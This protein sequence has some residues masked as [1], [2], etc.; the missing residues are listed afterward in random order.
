MSTTVATPTIPVRYYQKEADEAI[1]QELATSD[2][3]LV[4]MFCGTGKSLVMRY[5]EVA[6][7]K[8]LVVYV[9]PSLTLIHQFYTNYLQ[10]FPEQ[11]I[12]KVS[13]DAG[14]TTD[15]VAIEH[16]LSLTHNKI[17]CVTYNSYSMFLRCLDEQFIDVCIYDEAHH[18]MALTYSRQIFDDPELRCKKQVFFTATIKPKSSTARRAM[19][20][21]DPNVINICGNLV[22][23]YTFNQGVSEGYLSDFDV[24]ADIYKNKEQLSVYESISRAVLTT[25]NSRVLTFHCDVQADRRMSVKNFVDEPA[26]TKIFRTIQA[27]E[28]P[29]N[30][31][32]Y[33]K[34]V[35]YGIDASIPN[36]ERVRILN[37]MDQS[38]SSNLII[39]SS[40]NTVG[41]GVDTKR[42]N[43]CVFTEAKSSQLQ[44]IQNIGRIVRKEPGVNKPSTILIPCWID[45]Q[46]YDEFTPGTMDSDY[47]LRRDLFKDG[48]NFASILNVLTALKQ[49]EPEKFAMCINY[50]KLITKVNHNRPIADRKYTILP[51]YKDGSIGKT[52]N[53]MFQD[54]ISNK[55]EPVNNDDGDDDIFNIP[56]SMIVDSDIINYVSD[57]T[58]S[59]IEI[60]DKEPIRG[61]PVE[62]YS[63]TYTRKKNRR[64]LLRTLNEED[65]PQYQ[66][67]IDNSKYKRK[68]VYERK[69]DE[70][71]INIHTNP[72]IQVLWNIVESNTTTSYHS[73]KLAPNV[74]DPWTVLFPKLKEFLWEHHRL[75]R[76]GK[77]ATDTEIE[78]VKWYNAQ[79]A[80]YNE[81]INGMMNPE[82]YNK[83]TEFLS[84]FDV[85]IVD[86]LWNW[87]LEK[88]K[89]FIRNHGRT[90][91][92]N[93][94]IDGEAE[95]ALFLTHQKNQFR[96]GTGQMSIN[97]GRRIKW[98]NF[99]NE[100]DNFITN[101]TPVPVLDGDIP[102]GH[103]E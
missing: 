94:Y 103:N 35:M 82:R 88:L 71:S 27:E 76:S 65:K 54:E 48:G 101:R 53:R 19:Y 41:E 96:H 95:T 67:V 57:K 30:P 24:R 60:Y 44:I 39:I 13:S 11:Y 102:I 61:D 38:D 55:A 77:N 80:N 36:K 16:F 40:C 93:G 8:P 43:M 9:F 42:A 59:C 51:V 69:T 22:Y 70:P 83:W 52:L 31:I 47:M 7:N 81:G 73:C 29:N 37:E 12:L 100:F 23:D 56:I 79:T 3:C 4:R 15:A 89:T 49:T 58:K 84:E 6:H 99:V 34:I 75:P 25:G 26:F 66:I 86:G 21:S 18:A 62:S 50:P 72:D 1:T 5:C 33:D 92:R 2:K 45:K 32:K 78:L 97:Y 91:R 20:S 28:Y 63:I 98:L 87:N 85:Y 64:I 14:A 10:D 90:P 46:N 74:I 17:V 68:V